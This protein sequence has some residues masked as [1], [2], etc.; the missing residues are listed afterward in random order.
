[1]SKRRPPIEMR[2]QIDLKYKLEG[3]SIIIYEVRPRWNDQ[4]KTTETNVA[5]ATYVKSKELWK[6]YWMQ[7]D[8]KWHAYDPAPM[9][10]SLK[11]FLEIVDE[12]KHGCFRG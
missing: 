1:M 11:V 12:D 7:G 9:A 2:D 3:Q 4:S 5:K 8:L 10:G 6:V